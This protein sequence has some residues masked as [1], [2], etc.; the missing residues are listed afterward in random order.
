M[1]C[2]KGETMKHIDHQ[3]VEEIFNDALELPA[4]KRARFL[5]EE[6]GADAE[7]CEEVE[8]LLAAHDETFLEEDLSESVLELIR[9]GLLPGDV[10]NNRYEIIE[11]LGRG[12]MGEVY[13]AKDPTMG[14]KVA[15][16]LVRGNFDQDRKR[17]KSFVNEARAASQINHPNILTVHDFIEEGD[18]SF[19]ITEYVEGGTLREKLQSHPLDLPTTLKLTG[20]VASALEAAHKKGVVHRDIK[21]ENI[22]INNDGHVKIL[23]FGIAKLTERESSENE[24]TTFVA[25]Q[26]EVEDG[27][28]TARYMSPEQVRARYGEQHVDA[29]SDIWSLG[30]CL[31]E[32]LTG[33]NP[34]KGESSIDTLAAILKVEPPPPGQNVPAPLKAVLKKAL[35]KKRDDRYQTMREFRSAL[36]HMALQPLVN[37]PDSTRGMDAFEEWRRTAGKNIWRVLL[38]GALLCLVISIALT[39]YLSGFFNSDISTWGEGAAQGAQAV[40]SLFHLI[41]LGVAFGYFYKNPGLKEFRPIASD[42]ENNRLKPIIT[43]STGYEKI[44][45]W[46]Q[47]RKIARTALKDYREIFVGLLF[48]WF[49]LYA[50]TLLMLK[51]PGEFL[52]ALYTQANN[53][54]TLCIWLCFRILNEPITTE[55]KAQN[56]K[57]IVIKESLKGQIGLLMIVFVLMVFWS[58]LEYNFAADF[59]GPPEL[60]HKISKLISGIFGGVAMALFVGRFQSKF[61]KSPDWLIITLYLYTVIQTLFIFYGDKSVEGKGWAAVVIHAA[62]FLKCLLILYMFWLFQSGRLLFYLVRVRRASTQVDGEW[63]TFREVLRRES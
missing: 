24:T 8:S 37:S 56:D 59:T 43:Y 10:I 26:P 44:S 38:Y 31:Y 29:R 55:N 49:S 4:D 23:D 42:I 35:Q 17:I 20:E 62:L 2:E 15:V 61:L 60:V 46:E 9:G 34:F 45:D 52:T 41:L 40:G 39:T 50:C 58:I 57:S 54:N 5:S 27:F 63:Q 18:A 7:L 6:C 14:R 13:L 48:A 25:S 12:G 19:I 11:L 51:R 3:K 33:V 47:A 22:G 1:A 16:K 32:M 53:F 30:V 21:P 28:G 36:E